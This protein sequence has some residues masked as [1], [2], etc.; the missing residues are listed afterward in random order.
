MP[1]GRSTVYFPNYLAPHTDAFKDIEQYKAVKKNIIE[2]LRRKGKSTLKN[3]LY[4]ESSLHK[5][6]IVKFSKKIKVEEIFLD[7]ITNQV[8]VLAPEIKRETKEARRQRT[9]FYH[10]FIIT[11]FEAM[12]TRGIAETY[13]SLSEEGK[14][15]VSK[16]KKRKK[17][18]K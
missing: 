13:L 4:I 6:G 17:M 16:V 2:A 10:Q 15:K 12:I 14:L 7:P 11:S 1:K 3:N 5:N 8:I 9:M 18:R